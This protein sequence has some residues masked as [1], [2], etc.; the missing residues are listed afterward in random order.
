MNKKP[1][2]NLF[3]YNKVRCLTGY[4]RK[5]RQLIRKKIKEKI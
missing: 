4:S 3:V 5:E 2:Y 1:L